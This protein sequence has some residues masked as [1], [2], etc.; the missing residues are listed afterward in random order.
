MNANPS[1]GRPRIELWLTLLENRDQRGKLLG[2]R[3]RIRS[4]SSPSS[5][6]SPLLRSPRRGP[7]R[8]GQIFSITALLGLVTRSPVSPPI[9]AKLVVGVALRVRRRFIPRRSSRNPSSPAPSA[10]GASASP[11]PVPPSTPSARA[12]PK[13]GEGEA[14]TLPNPPPTC[15]SRR[16]ARPRRPRRRR[17]RR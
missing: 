13:G 6:S 12:R 17:R 9:P 15:V 7:R 5:P 11:P 4:A 14:L 2:A 1:H 10:P 16:S 8:G 3:R